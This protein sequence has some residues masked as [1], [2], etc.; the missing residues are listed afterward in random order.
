MRLVFIVEAETTTALIAE[1]FTVPVV[2]K[3]C[4]YT[5]PDAVTSPRIS[6]GNP[7]VCFELV[8]IGRKLSKISL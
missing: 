1:V 2:K 7:N 8:L 3:F 5:P 6:T 4:A